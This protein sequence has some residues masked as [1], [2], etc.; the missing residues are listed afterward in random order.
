MCKHELNKM[1]A[2]LKIVMG[3]IAVMTMILEMTDCEKKLLQQK[4]FSLVHCT[5]KCTKKS[6]IEF[7]HKGLQ[8]KVNRLQSSGA[9]ELMHSTF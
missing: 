5:D 6:F 7:N 9:K 4:A 8:D 2:R 3:D 1:Q